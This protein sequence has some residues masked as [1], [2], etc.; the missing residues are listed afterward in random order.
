MGSLAHSLWQC[1][2]CN[3]CH[4]SISQFRLLLDMH[5]SQRT[6]SLMVA[7]QLLLLKDIPLPVTLHKVTPRLVHTLRLVTHHRVPTPH[8][9]VT[10]ASKERTA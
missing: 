10:M 6:G 9:R 2:L 3:R 4:A 1:L 5:Q 7:I 8:H